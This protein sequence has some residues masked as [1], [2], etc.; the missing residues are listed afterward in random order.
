MSWNTNH[1]TA[2]DYARQ[3]GDYAQ[4]KAGELE[5]RVNTA[6][7]NTTD[8]AE[9][10]DARGTFVNL[11]ERL[12]TEVGGLAQQL[13]QK[14]LKMTT[15]T[16][17]GVAFDTSADN[18]VSW[19]HCNVSY[20]ETDDSFF[21]VYN[22][23]PTHSITQ[24]KVY[25]RKKSRNGEFSDVIVIASRLGENIS[26]KCQSSGIAANG[27]YIAII[28][29][30]NPSTG[31]II[32]TFL[33]RSLD[34]GVT[35]DS[36]TEIIVSGSSVIAYSGDVSGFRTLSTGRIILWGWFQDKKS[37]ALYSDNHGVNWHY[38]TIQGSP[39]NVTEPTFIELDDGTIIG[40]ARDNV[41][42]GNDHVDNPKPAWFL[43]STTGGSSWETPV[44]S[45]SILDM[46]NN[47]CAFV[48]HGDLVEIIFGSRFLHEDGYGSIYQAIT[49]QNSLLNDEWNQPVRI[50][51]VNGIPASMSGDGDSGYYGSATAKDGTSL[52]F[53][54]NGTKSASKIYY[55][56]GNFN[57]NV[58]NDKEKELYTGV[59]NKTAGELVL[60]DYSGVKGYVK[61]KRFATGKN[62]FADLAVAGTGEAWIT[63]GKNEGGIDTILTKV[64]LQQDGKVKIDNLNVDNLS[65]D[66]LD[67]VI[68]SDT[69]NQLKLYIDGNSYGRLTFG[70]LS[71]L[72]V[73]L[74]ET[75]I[76][77]QIDNAVSLGTTNKRFKNG[78]F[79]GV[80]GI[81][82]YTTTEKPTTEL[83]TG[84]VIYNKT[85]RRLEIYDSTITGNWMD[86]LGRFISPPATSTS[87]GKKGDF[88]ADANYFYVCYADNSWIRVA[89]DS[90]W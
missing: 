43:K 21:V 70:N 24:S 35:W 4:T 62:L 69:I 6:I 20:D 14:A 7:G 60:G 83:I 67:H 77:N 75:A 25:A 49:T 87:A 3:Q 39:Y 15:F 79:A 55:L 65:V 80:V 27:D 19:T 41:S 37:F 46:S 76:W 32:G 9:I 8:S 13:E 54:Y 81:P 33:Y 74:S 12:D 73:I 48:K 85:T 30:I 82:S 63:F 26:A 44:L 71:P 17:Q 34:K 57:L 50:A 64:V 78:Y 68:I 1:K 90:T 61:T 31:A 38:A 10:I 2:A 52:V 88:S 53:Y 47:N 29:H 36:G 51:R 23:Q 86:T 42:D 84:S 28:A 56:K 11:R 58:F 72:D 16:E 5:Q 89:K 59:E 45:K 66:Y 40:Y 18:H 22:A